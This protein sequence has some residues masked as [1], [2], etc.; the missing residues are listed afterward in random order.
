MSLKRLKKHAKHRK[1]KS[2]FAILEPLD[3]RMLL[4]AAIQVYG[5]SNLISDGSDTP[6]ISQF[7]DF[8]DMP[9]DLT[10]AFS[11]VTRTFSIK[12]TGDQ[13][14]LLSNNPIVSII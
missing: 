10:G 4:S 11:Q 1:S 5:A 9:T 13:D 12:N 7:T 3:A 14:L 6:T 2:C 8:R